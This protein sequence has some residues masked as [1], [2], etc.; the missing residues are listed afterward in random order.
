MDNVGMADFSTLSLSTVPMPPSTL[1]S[2]CNEGFPVGSPLTLVPSVANRVTRARANTVADSGVLGLALYAGVEDAIVRV[3][4]LGVL[5]LTLAQW[6]VIVATDSGVLVPGAAYYLSQA[7]A[8]L[9]TRTQPA[10]GIVVKLGLALSTRAL[11]IQIDSNELNP[12]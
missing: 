3:R 6:A 10:S 5:T 4:Q 8:G 7:T 11:S 12:G 9:L 2:T 1:I